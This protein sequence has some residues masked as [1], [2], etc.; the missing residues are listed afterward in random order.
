MAVVM[1]CRS[2]KRNQSAKWVTPFRPGLT[3][4]SCWHILKHMPT[5]LPEA[6]MQPERHVRLFRNGRSQ[7]IRIP[8]EFELEGNEAIIHKDG[9]RLI[10]EPLKKKS[11]RALLAGWRPLADG[12]P[13]IDDPPVETEEIF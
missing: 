11:L 3:S 7:A 9:N 4:Q 10:I 1:I 13:E 2:Q 5:N 6:I 12:L 8:K